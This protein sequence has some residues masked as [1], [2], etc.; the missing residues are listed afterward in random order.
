[1]SFPDVWLDVSPDLPAAARR[2]RWYAEVRKH[3][4][5]L[6]G[7]CRTDQLFGTSTI[8]LDDEGH[9]IR[10]NSALLVRKD[11]TVVSRYD[12]VHRVPFGEYVPFK[13]WLPF[14]DNFAPYENDYSI[15]KGEHLT[16][17][18]LGKYTFGVVI[19]N[20]DTDPFLARA[21]GRD[22]DDGPA[23]DFLLNIS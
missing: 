8:Y 9:E 10:Y 15:R 4:H 21:Y 12:K 5:D 6:A 20:E 16:R 14:M 1:T 11:G 22:D 2:P 7:F 13:D 23:V 17:L 3:A 19:C 18:T